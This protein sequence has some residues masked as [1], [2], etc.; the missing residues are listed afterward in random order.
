MSDA[1]LNLTHMYLCEFTAIK[2]DGTR[3]DVCLHGC[4]KVKL[5]GSN[6]SEKMEER[7]NVSLHTEAIVDCD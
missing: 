1:W 7:T 3:A 5:S 6:Y 4:R 2:G